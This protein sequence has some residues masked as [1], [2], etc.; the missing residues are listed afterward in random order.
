MLS[1]LVFIIQFQDR[2]G[3][4]VQPILNKVDT[5][6]APP[7]FHRTNKFTKGFQVLIEAYGVATYR[8]VNPGN[9]LGFIS[10]MSPFPSVVI[11]IFNV[12]AHIVFKYR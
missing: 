6:I 8:E 10:K 2:S 12:K 9:I 11:F 4:S 3:S 7:T 1:N 5:K